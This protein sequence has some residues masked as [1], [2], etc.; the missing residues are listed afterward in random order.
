MLNMKYLRD[1]FGDTII[2]ERLG[3][4]DL[5][6]NREI[7]LIE[8]QN[9][10]CGDMIYIG[11]QQRLAELLE[12]KLNVEQ[13]ALVLAADAAEPLAERIFR[14][15][16]FSLIESSM[17]VAECYNLL[18]GILS[19]YRHWQT[20]L[21]S[22]RGES[23]QSIIEYLAKESGASVFLVDAEGYVLAGCSKLPKKIPVF[24][25][26]LSGGRM[27]AGQ[28]SALE[29]EG[30]SVDGFRTLLYEN[31]DLTLFSRSL[32]FGNK[33][34]VIIF[35]FYKLSC[36]PDLSALMHYSEETLRFS[37]LSQQRKDLSKDDADF[38]LLWK[39]IVGK[40]FNNSAEIRSELSKASVK[41]Q[42]FARVVIIRFEEAPSEQAALIAELHGV[43][44]ISRIT[45]EEAQA[46]VLL[47]HPKRLFSSGIES[48]LRLR[49]F[50]E[51]HDAYLGH[52]GATREYN[53]IPTLYELAKQVLTLG[54]QLALE[55]KERI[56]TNERYSVF[57]MIEL[58]TQR[59]CDVHGNNNIVFLSHPAIIHLTRFDRDH[60]NNLR[61]VLYVY[62]MNDCSI[63]K[64][65]AITFMHRNTIFNKLKKIEEVLH[66]NFEDGA[67][68][69]QLLFSC[70]LIFYY[71]RVMKM[72]LNLDMGRDEIPG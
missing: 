72:Q 18:N 55:S 25:S 38:K 42:L 39:D 45:L 62:L 43:F 71:E 68:R 15:R 50:L 66:I 37:F 40:R 36:S 30:E 22:K 58:C 34:A 67:I 65:A 49:A 20:E 51:K 24:R 69:Q 46:V 31:Y 33:R 61:D 44:P 29:E 28:L 10:L 26:L 48:E 7:E 23:P 32:L 8:R 21:L 1:S 13:G 6:E 70:Q 19:R 52:S 2:S 5:E 17:S 27:T 14:L 41:P 56:F 16:N 35:A 64:T 9:T 54:R 4:L 47:Y 60:N 53:M 57:C 11:T 12:H 63:S 59:F 3:S